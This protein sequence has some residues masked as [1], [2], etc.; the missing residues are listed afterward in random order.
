MRYTSLVLVARCKDEAGN[1]IQAMSS[2]TSRTYWEH[3]QFRKGGNLL[4]GLQKIP[5]NKDTKQFYYSFGKVM[6]FQSKSGMYNPYTAVLGP[7]FNW[8]GICRL[9][10]EKYFLSSLLVNL[11]AKILTE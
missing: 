10:F 7:V 8:P 9:I 11:H 1:H 4:V 5:N 2:V 3:H 6:N